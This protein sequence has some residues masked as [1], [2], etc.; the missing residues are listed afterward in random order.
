MVVEA[1]G[2]EIYVDCMVDKEVTNIFFWPKTYQDLCWY[3]HDKILAI[4][5]QPVCTYNAADHFSVD[6]A[7]WRALEE[8]LRARSI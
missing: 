5:P 2:E 7:I 1:D 6:E 8:K 3:D 4:I